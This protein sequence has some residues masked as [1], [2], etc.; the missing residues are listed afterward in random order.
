MTTRTRSGRRTARSVAIAAPALVALVVR[1]NIREPEMWHTAVRQVG[2]AVHPEFS[3]GRV[4]ELFHKGLLRNTLVGSLMAFVAVFGLWGVTYWTPVLIRHAPDVAQLAE[5][6]TVHRVSLAMMILN[7]GA[8][9]GYLAFAPITI[10]IGRRW[11]FFLFFLGALAM[12]PTLFLKIRTYQ[13]ILWLLP[14]LGF[15]TNGIFTGFA[16]YFPELY[17]TRLRTTGAGFCFNFARVFASTGPYLTGALT[18]LFGSFSRAV[19]AVG[20]IY[21]LG[22]LLLPFAPETRGKDLPP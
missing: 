17:P 7:V 21:L 4:Q 2:S 15:F 13:E 16:I 5:T 1:R 20:T 8:L 9:A 6:L 14:L 3:V 10:R 12:V 19:T 18:G 22:L 11:A